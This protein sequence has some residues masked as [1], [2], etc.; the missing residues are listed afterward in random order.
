[1]TEKFQARQ[2]DVFVFRVETLPKERKEVQRENGLVILALGEATGHHHSI[3][4]IG[5]EMF[6]TANTVDR[7]LRIGEAGAT[8]AHQEHAAINLPQGDYIV[9]IQREYNPEMTRQVTD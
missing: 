3:A 5:V 6:E 4:D 1:M 8:L 9:R 7:W 2:G